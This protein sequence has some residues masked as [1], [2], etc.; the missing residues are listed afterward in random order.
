MSELVTAFRLLLEAIER[1]AGGRKRAQIV[2]YILLMV[3]VG[4]AIKPVWDN[5]GYIIGKI[6][7]SAPFVNA[8]ASLI[9]IVTGFVVVFALITLIAAI[10]AQILRSIFDSSY[11]IRL[12]DTYIALLTCLRTAAHGNLEKEQIQELLESTEMLYQRWSKTKTNILV[13]WVAP[14]YWKKD[15]RKWDV[16]LKKENNK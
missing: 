12:N 7:F 13:N 14:A 2:F 6:D 10:P 11:R 5:I 3:V 4:L 15:N 9:F 8:I 1:M 16:V